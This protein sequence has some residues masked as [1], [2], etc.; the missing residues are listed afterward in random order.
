MSARKKKTAPKQKKLTQAQ[1]DELV[2][3]AALTLLPAVV[4]IGWTNE[5]VFA[6]ADTFVAAWLTWKEQKSNL[7]E[8]PVGAA[9]KH[10][11]ALAAAHGR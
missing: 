3:R 6:A 10:N 8:D 7:P 1:R 2:L 11:M 4:T 5:K 9:L